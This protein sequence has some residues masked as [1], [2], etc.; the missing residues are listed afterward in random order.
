MAKKRMHVVT[1][2]HW[3][4]EHRHGFQ[5]TR[6]MLV[7]QTD[8]LIGI[9]EKDPDF[10]FFV[11]DG[12]SVVLEDYL[13]V[14]P[15]MRDRL[16]AL[17]ESGRIL[18]GPWY[19][20]PD[21]FAP[22]P[23]SLI[24]NLLCGDRLCRQFGA[25]MDFGYSIFSF[26]QIAQLPQI[27]S[28]FGIDDMIF[29]KGAGIDNFK[30]AEFIWEAPDGTKALVSRLGIMNRMN[31]LFCFTIPVILG[32]D[33]RKPGWEVSFTDGTKLAHL[34]D[35]KLYTQ[36]A[37]ELEQ[38]IRIRKEKIA[39]GVK[40]VMDS[41]TDSCSESVF[42]GFDGVDF[43]TPVKE[44][45]EALKLANEAAGDEV[46]IIHSTP[47]AYFE[48]LRKDI[49]LDSLFVHKGEARFGPQGRVHSETLSAGNIIKQ[50]NYQAEIDLL[51]YAEPFSAFCKI[52][53]GQ[54]PAD[55][56]MTA[57]KYLF[58]THAHDSIHG[59][60]V[61]KLIPDNIFQVAQ[62]Q[63]IADSVSK[64][65]FEGVMSQIDTS[66]FDDDD[67]LITVFNPTA[68]MRSDVV[69]VKIDLPRQEFVVDYSIEQLD[70]KEVPMYEYEKTF[71]NIASVN[72]EN[73]PKAVCCKRADVDLFVEDVPAFGYKTLKVK[74][75]RGDRP[76]Q[77]SPFP[78]PKFA[79]DSIATLPNVLDNGLLKAQINPNGTIDVTDLET[80]ITYE[81]LN[82]FTDTGC[83]GDMWVHRE[84]ENNKVITNLG[85]A[86][87][88]SLVRNCFLSASFQ[89][90][91]VLDIPDS[92]SQDRKSRSKHPIP[93]KISTL[94]TLA[95]DSKRLDFQVSME[96]R[97][98]DHKL[99]ASFPTGIK[100]ETSYSE[101][102]FEIKQRPI[103]S[104]LEKNVYTG[105]QLLRHPMHGF[106]DISD[107]S[108]GVALFS[109]GLKEFE[110]KHYDK[111]LVTCEL[112]LLR[113]MT[114][115]FPVHEDVFVS[116]EKEESQ[117]IGEHTFDY[118]LYFHKG[119]YI[120][121]DVIA[122]SR[123]Y[124]TPLAA[125]QY[126]KGKKGHLP[127][128]VGF[129]KLNNRNT[130]VSCIKKAEDRDEIIVRLNNPT[131]KAIK[132]KV[133]FFNPVKKAFKTDFNEAKGKEIAVTKDNAVELEIT[134]YRIETI[135]LAF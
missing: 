36:H 88:I 25:K 68:H 27:Y 35:E 33:A 40:D 15:H 94:V 41:V 32:G 24:R 7:E 63:E 22:N 81:G 130:I 11:F 98:K 120:E 122:Q 44:L 82:L 73:R 114:Q 21:M 47:V 31:F 125:G 69:N 19:S 80:K 52:N 48:E 18:I 61:A 113:S 101:A 74:R 10:K 75:T 37:I 50:K 92:L 62:A 45:P 111:G 126:G 103:V 29:Y 104:T 55:I 5:E 89:V 23:E 59:T 84:P 85:S 60:G 95:K 70:G 64:R 20:L 28:G 34:I 30:K 1:N 123:I 121:G 54:Y 110:T 49:D 26:G 129:L 72:A 78:D 133:E 6:L 87:E 53:G 100:T 43:S 71:L 46:E 115:T 38:D 14:K 131:G 2:T 51:H 124:P 8:K 3:D 128:E 96:N 119:D 65:A 127:T 108:K 4:R 77:P 76:E 105:A 57:W 16:A 13:E 135:S 83:S 116:F 58:K 134:P 66:I 79:L 9:M 109:K 17:I 97:C 12:Q 106:L 42:I 93:T 86:A 102:P 99:T 132:E 67:I 112:T 56:L 117:C 91:V 90:D 107:G 118:S 39:Q